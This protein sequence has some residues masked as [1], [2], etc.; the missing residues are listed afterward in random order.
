[1]KQKTAEQRIQHTQRFNWTTYKQLVASAKKNK[2]S[3]SAEIEIRVERTLTTE[4]VA[5]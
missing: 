3:I 5:A 2:R 1:M 4:G